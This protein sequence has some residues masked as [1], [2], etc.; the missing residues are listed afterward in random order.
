MR[1]VPQDHTEDS[2]KE[3]AEHAGQE[4][5]SCVP[6]EAGE[7]DLRHDSTLEKI[8]VLEVDPLWCGSSHSPYKAVPYEKKTINIPFQKAK[9]LT[10]RKLGRRLE[11][12]RKGQRN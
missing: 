9:K 12:R 1:D 4:A 3:R 8:S 7:G 11:K 2:T 5:E 6:T 10:I